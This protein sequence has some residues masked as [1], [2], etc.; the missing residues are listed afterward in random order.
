MAED[1]FIYFDN[2][3]TTMTD[4]E[5]IEAMLPYLNEKFGN[6]SSF[7]EFGSQINDDIKIAREQVAALLNAD[8]DEIYFTSGSTESNN[9]AIKG[10]ALANQSKG[11]HLIISSVEHYS[12][13]HSAEFLKQLGFEISQIPVDEF[14]IIKIEEFKKLLRA[15]TILVSVNFANGEVGSLQPI[16]EITDILKERKI[17]FHTDAV[18][19]VGYIPIDVKKLNI[20]M[21]GFSGHRFYGPKGTGA[22]Y[23]KK[24]IRILP[25]INGGVQESGKRAGTENVPGI[26]GLG[27]AAE[28]AQKQMPSYIPKLTELRN[29]LTDGILEKIER[30]KLNGHPEKRL[31]NFVNIS[32]EFLEGESILMMLIMKG[33]MAASGSACQSKALKVS[34]VLTAMGV[35]ADLA[36]GSILFS[37]GKHNTMEEVEYTI[38]ELPTIIERL[39]MMSPLYHKFKKNQ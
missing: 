2:I 13:S 33:I 7:Y 29:K 22:L 36:Q 8:P 23:V 3:A 5:V 35:P 38:K 12:V 37:L 19:S 6:P 24:G 10:F 11:K 16:N 25:L 26:I 1:K 17:V 34:P 9:W 18:Q 27:K 39:R 31:P 28:L 4:P 20:D 14:G 15:D 32:Y 21:L 30:V